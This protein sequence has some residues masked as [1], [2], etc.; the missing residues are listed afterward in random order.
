MNKSSVFISIVLSVFLMSCGKDGAPG[1]D[2]VSIVGPQGPAGAQGPAGQAAV[3]EIIDPCGDAPG[4]HDEVIL[5]LANGQLLASFSQ[6]ASGL[7]T[8]FSILTQGNYITS[9]GSNCH[10]SV[11]SDNQVLN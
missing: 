5:R 8:R 6:N 4:I 7:N 9:D 2:G 3:L 1:K 10:F 11:T